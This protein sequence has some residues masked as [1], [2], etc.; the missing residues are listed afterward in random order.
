[1]RHAAACAVLVTLI[2]I[3]YGVSLGHQFVFDDTSLVVDNELV[4]L[5]LSRAGELLTGATGGIS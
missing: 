2:V 3:V 1:M 5:P 4:Q